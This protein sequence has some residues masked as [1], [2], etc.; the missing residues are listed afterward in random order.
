MQEY[1]VS[2]HSDFEN[3]QVSVVRNSLGEIVMEIEEADA[4]ALYDTGWQTPRPFK[5]KARD[6]VTDIY[7]VMVV[8]SNFD[9]NKSYPIVNNIYPGPQVGSVGSRSFS[10]SRRGQIQALAELGF[11]VVQ[12]DGFGTPMRSSEFHTYYYGDMSD[13]GLPDQIAAMQQLAEKYDFIDIDRAGIFGHS[14]GGFATASALF[15]HPSFSRLVSQVQVTTT[16]GDTRTTGVK[17]F[18]DCLKRLM[19]VTPIPIRR[20]SFRPKTWKAT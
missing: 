9:P 7:G 16:T 17:S 10:S 20:T 3:P 12:V 4:S 14:G 11:V 5:V 15:Q 19:M 6:G 8:P 1:I 2:T 18:R 13:N